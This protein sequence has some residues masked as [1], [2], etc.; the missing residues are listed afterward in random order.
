MAMG[1]RVKPAS[2][3]PGF[4]ILFEWI[5]G[6]KRQTKALPK[7]DWG[8]RGFHLQMTWDQACSRRDAL[9]A[10]EKLKG[11]EKK[12]HKIAARQEG[13]K[14]KQ[15]AY[16]PP[17]DLRGFEEKYG[18]ND[19]NSKKRSYWNKA[20]QIVEAV[21]L[22]PEEWE[23]SPEK[24]YREYIK[25]KMSPAYVQ[26]VQPLINRWGAFMSKRYKMPFLP[27]P[28]PPK[29][30]AADIAETH[31]AKTR[32]RGN[33]ESEPLTPEALQKQ[34]AKL[35]ERHYRWLILSVWFGLR[36]IEVDSLKQPSSKRTWFVFEGGSAKYL[37]IYQSKLKGVEPKKR[38]KRIPCYHPEQVKALSVIG[39]DIKRPNSKTMF[40]RFGPNITLYGGRKGFVKLMKSF[41]H[42]FEN[43]SAWLGHLDVNRTYQDYFDRSEEAA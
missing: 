31:F 13:I 30:W 16:F 7:Q 9:N 28:A 2:S 33:R 27:L 37:C 18:L 21:A 24:F 17:A 19:P 14:L 42:S 3:A 6:G 25:H 5:E 41:G 11:I 4:K 12:R 10:Q 36:P 43:V 32:S 35:T 39:P 26:K 34:A 29:G 40:K 20:R 23:D 1:Y 8:S 38:I 22:P 15:T